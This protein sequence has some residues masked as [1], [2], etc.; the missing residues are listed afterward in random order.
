MPATR[1]FSGGAGDGNYNTLT[2]WTAL[3]LPVTGD[4]VIISANAATGINSNLDR[5]GDDMGDGLHLAS[6]KVEDGF[7]YAIGG[8]SNP[9]RLTATEFIDRGS[10]LTYFQTQTGVAGNDTAQVVLDKPGGLFRFTDHSGSA[11]LQ[12]DIVQGRLVEI[13]APNFGLGKL[14]VYPEAGDPSAVNVTVS[15]GT[16][17]AD[18]F[19]IGGRCVL[20]NISGVVTAASLSGGEMQFLRGTLS[21]ITHAG[22]LFLHDCPTGSGTLSL[23]YAM[24]GTLDSTR[25]GGA[26]AITAMFRPRSFEIIPNPELSITS[27]NLIGE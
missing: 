12:F 11:V 1:T 24:Y 10:G 22:G 21:K 7:K 26:K 8:S 23:Y 13:V 16:D 4:S 2:N 19:Q 3:T 15:G 14:H 9:L 20:D 27:N 17:I 5:T 25:T 18:L 6:F